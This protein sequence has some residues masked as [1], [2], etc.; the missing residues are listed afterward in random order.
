MNPLF[1]TLGVVLIALL[2]VLLG[3]VFSRFRKSYWLFGYFLPLALIAVLV[4]VRFNN[5][6]Y[7]VQPFSWITTG[8][9]KFVIL[10][11]SVTM[12]LS[13]TMSRLPRK[14]ER[15]L[16]QVLMVIVVIWFAV[17]PFLVPALLKNHLLNLKTKLNSNGIC[18]QSTDYTCGPAAAVTALRKLGL[19]ADEGQIAVLSYTSPVTGTLPSCLSSA[20]QNHYGQAGLKCQF[21]RF[22]SIEQLRNA[23]IT[24]AIVRETFLL[25][26]CLAVLEVSDHTVTVADPAAGTKMMSHRQFEKIWRFS[27]I[28]LE[29]NQAQSI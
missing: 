8:R 17:L 4:L 25:D 9:T 6:F 18:F 14:F 16:V 5:M 23:G 19:P 3:K 11:L 24:L 27:G 12:G 10:S 15:L 22:D 28:V 7:F 26:H 1:E 20:I 21:R 29:R 2:G 13:V